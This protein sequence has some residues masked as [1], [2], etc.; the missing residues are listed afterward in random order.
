MWSPDGRRIAFSSNSRGQFDLYVKALDG[1]GGEHLLYASP[2][3]KWAKSWSPDG[4]YLAY[5]DV[6]PSGVTRTG[7]VASDLW[8]LAF[9]DP[10][11]PT[12]YLTSDTFEDTNVFSP[13]GSWMAYVADDETGRWNLFVSSFPKTET[14]RL[15]STNGL[16]AFPQ[17]FKWRLDGKEILYLSPSWTVMSVEVKAGKSF[18]AGEPKPLFQLPPYPGWDV[19]ADGER[20][21]VAESLTTGELT[22]ISLIVN[23]TA[24]LE[25]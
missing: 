2:T 25:Q 20:F 9:S 15:I 21:L 16:A 11:K 6:H 13:V 14:K 22:P 3:A 18:E 23:W 1:A 19:S 5:V 17:A 4:R 7:N 8:V 24:A 10:G 12:P